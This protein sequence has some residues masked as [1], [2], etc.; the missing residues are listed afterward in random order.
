MPHRMPG[1]CPVCS[2]PLSITGLK[3]KECETEI[4]GDFTGCQFCSLGSEQTRFLLTFLQCRG[5]LK[6]ME[7][8]LGI[9]YPTIKNRLEELISALN[10]EEPLPP[11]TKKRT[12]KTRNAVLTA[13]QKGE[14]TPEQSL[15]LLN[16]LP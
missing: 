9:S 3:C 14:I 7:K 13:L 10:L 15:S 1:S 8:R 5:S 4:H 12:Y 2:N 6:E 11:E 16:K